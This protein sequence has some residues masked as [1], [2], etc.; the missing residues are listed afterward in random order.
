MHVSNFMSFIGEQKQ[1]PV[2]SNDH[3]TEREVLLGKIYF[4][5]SRQI[6]TVIF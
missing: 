3:R 1:D 5:E 2:L 4:N 6:Y